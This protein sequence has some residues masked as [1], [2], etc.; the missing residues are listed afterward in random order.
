MAKE[1][2]SLKELTAEIAKLE[3]KKHESS[4]GDVREI[5]AVLSDLDHQ[6]E[7]QVSA[8]IAKNGARRAKKK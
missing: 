6:T 5:I 3:G 1:I 4:V 2:K 7:G 8:L